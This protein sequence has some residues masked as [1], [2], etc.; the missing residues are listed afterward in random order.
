MSSVN[1]EGTEVGTG[2][3]IVRAFEDEPVKLFDVGRVGRTI[4]VAAQPGHRAVGFPIDSVYR[5]TDADYD[6][7]RRAFER[8][9]RSAL[10]SIWE[11]LKHHV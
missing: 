2:R 4:L 3:I 5:Y 1:S 7:L 8:G 10:L 6:E 9:D 11:S